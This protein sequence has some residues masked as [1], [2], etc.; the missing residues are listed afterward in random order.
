MR[1][2]TRRGERTLRL[3][4]LLTRVFVGHDLRTYARQLVVHVGSA[5]TPKTRVREPTFRHSSRGGRRH[6]RRRSRTPWA[7]GSRS[8]NSRS[9]RSSSRVSP[10]IGARADSTNAFRASIKRRRD[11]ALFQP[12]FCPPIPAI[13]LNA[14]YSLRASLK[15]RFPPTSSSRVTLSMLVEI[16]LMR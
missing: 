3:R 7:R 13:W 14:D 6:R 5:A 15:M 10:E 4:C 12:A 16:S 8:R 2:V 11:R 1:R 9:R